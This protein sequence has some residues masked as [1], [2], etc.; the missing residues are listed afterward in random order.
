MD[1]QNLCY[2]STCIFWTR[3][4]GEQTWHITRRIKKMTSLPTLRN[5]PPFHHTFSSRFEFS[6][7]FQHKA[8]FYANCLVSLLWINV[9]RKTND[10]DEYDSHVQKKSLEGVALSRSCLSGSSRMSLVFVQWQQKSTMATSQCLTR[11]LE[12]DVG[13][14]REVV[15]TVR[16]RR[17]SSSSF[18]WIRYWH[19]GR[20]FVFGLT[21]AVFV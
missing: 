8:D 10:F 15:E 2:K 18:H 4:L 5:D 17:N 19:R 1:K 21:R 7:F 9:W 11:I 6:M 12:A 20:C 13:S 3:S 16:F 14:N